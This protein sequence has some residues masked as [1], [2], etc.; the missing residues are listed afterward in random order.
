MK[1][2]LEHQEVPKEEAAVET[3]EALEDRYGN[4]HLVGCR[5]WLKKRI[6]GHDGSRQKLVA[7]GWPAVQYLHRASDKV[8]RDQARMI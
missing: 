2:V 5:G 3:I 7:D 8:V 1:S 4:Q 6:K